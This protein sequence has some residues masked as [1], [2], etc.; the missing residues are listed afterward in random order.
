LWLLLK[1]KSILLHDAIKKRK[2]EI[3]KLLIK[4]GIDYNACDEV[5]VVVVVVVVVFG[6]VVYIY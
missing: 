6:V 4:K 3:A 2:C 5:V 1:Y